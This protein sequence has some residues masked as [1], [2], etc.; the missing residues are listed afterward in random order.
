ML[1][2]FRICT[3]LISSI[4]AYDGLSVSVRAQLRASRPDSHAAGF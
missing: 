2:K 3:G 1:R 4:E